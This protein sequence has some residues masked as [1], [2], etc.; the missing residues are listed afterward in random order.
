[1]FQTCLV[2][3]Y[4]DPGGPKSPTRNSVQSHEL[5]FVHKLTWRSV[6]W[7]ATGCPRLTHRARTLKAGPRV[8]SQRW[9]SLRNFVQRAHTFAIQF[10][11]NS[12]ENDGDGH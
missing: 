8:Y 12:G 5:R 11:T 4:A 3:S 7:L 9:M 2:I 10:N 1:M 6:S